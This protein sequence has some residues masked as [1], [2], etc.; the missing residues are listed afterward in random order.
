MA[1]NNWVERDKHL[2]AFKYEE[3]DY[4]QLVVLAA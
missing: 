1:Y 2:H 4:F 3:K